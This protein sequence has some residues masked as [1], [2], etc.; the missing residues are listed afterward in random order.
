MNLIQ[1]LKSI[2]VKL[3]DKEQKIELYRKD[4]YTVENRVGELLTENSNLNEINR[5]NIV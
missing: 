2:T 1:K 3:E 5:K 4:S